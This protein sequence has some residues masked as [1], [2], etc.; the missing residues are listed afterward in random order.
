M[1]GLLQDSSLKFTAAL[2]NREAEHTFGFSE[3]PKEKKWLMPV[4]V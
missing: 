2:C 3:M 1:A 4:L